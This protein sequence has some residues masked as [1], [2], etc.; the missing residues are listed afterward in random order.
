MAAYMEGQGC[1]LCPWAALSGDSQAIHTR[2]V[3]AP[4]GWRVCTISP[5]HS[6][7]DL[8]VPAFPE[9]E[10]HLGSSPLC[11]FVCLFGVIAVVVIFF[12]PGFCLFV[13]FSLLVLEKV[14]GLER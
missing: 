8:C 5:P 11:L 1:Q 12:P 6:L 4:C 14:S 7:V 3:S 13:F 9:S 2:P 10:T